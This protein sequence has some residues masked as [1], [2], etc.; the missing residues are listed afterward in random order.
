MGTKAIDQLGWGLI[1]CGDIAAKRVAA[2]LRDAPHSELVSVSRARAELLPAFAAQ[3]GARRFSA[4]WRDLLKDSEIDAIYLAT[5]VSLHA[6][7][8]IAAAE[9]GKHVLCEKPMAIDVEACAR[10]IAA[11][12][13]NDVRLGVAYY[14]HHYPVVSRLRAILASGEIGSPVLALAQAFEP[15]NPGPDHPRAWL[16]RKTASGGGPMADFGCHR[17]EVL[18][19]LLGRVTRSRGFPTNVRFKD[20]EVEDTCVAHLGFESGA[21]AS[22]SVSHAAYER[23]DTLEII[24]TLGSAAVPVLN[25]GRLRLT[26]DAGAREEHHPPHPN[27]HQPLIEDFVAAVREARDP[28]VPGEAGLEVQHVLAAIYDDAP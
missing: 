13:A 28:A 21:Q 9:A 3:H 26:T 16:L 19:D 14:R 4:D 25:D 8:A 2:A 20:R 11:A 15:F 1:G 5:P 22:I 17:I 24:G 18:L 10:M 6:E 23:R 7:Q 12:R 27:L